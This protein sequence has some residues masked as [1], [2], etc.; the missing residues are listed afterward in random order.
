M[1]RADGSRPSQ[2]RTNS[3]AAL[4]MTVEDRRF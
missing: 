1:I 2:M 3:I 4:Q